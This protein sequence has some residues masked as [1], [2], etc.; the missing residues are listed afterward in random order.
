MKHVEDILLVRATYVYVCRTIK[1]GINKFVDY[2]DIYSPVVSQQT[3][4]LIFTLAIVKNWHIHSIAFVVA[5]PQADIKAD[6]FKK[7]PTV[8]YDFTIPDLSSPSDRLFKCYKLLKHLY[9]FKDADRAWNHYLCSCLLQQGWKQSPIDECVFVKKGVLL[10]L[11][12]DDVCIISPSK[13]LIN[14]EIKSLQNNHDLKDDG[15]L[16]YYLGTRFN[17]HTYGSVTLTQ[18]RMIDRILTIVD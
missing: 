17:C 8:T 15:E 13:N 9:G 16:Q 11:Y 3:I 2:W 5:F 10:I 6:I 4:H 18:P 12:V 1:G 14:H 7:F